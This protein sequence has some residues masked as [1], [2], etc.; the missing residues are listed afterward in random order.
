METSSPEPDP[1]KADAR[2]GHVTLDPAGDVVAGSLGAW[3]IVYTV[4]ACG[5]SPGG[6]IVLAR[7]WPADWGQPQWTAPTQRDYVTFSTTGAG[8]LV[9]RFELKKGGL[10]W[11]PDAIHALFV[12]VRD[13]TLGPGDRITV[14]LGDASAGSPG[15]LAQTF[16]EEAS[17]L[18][19]A[20][21]VY[22][23]GQWQRLPPLPAL[24][25][26]GGPAA[27]LVVLAPSMVDM[28][29]SFEVILRVED[30]WGNPAHGYGGCILL[31]TEGHES[32]SR[33][34]GGEDAGVARLPYRLTESGV[35]RLMARDEADTLSATSN[36]IVCTPSSS[37]FKLFWGD[38]H[39]QSQMGCGAR[40]V[41]DFLRHARDVAGVDFAAEQANDHYLSDAKWA[42]TQRV[43]RELHDP[44]RFVTFLGYEWS[45]ETA[46][47]GDHNVYYL[48]DEGPIRRS[49]HSLIPDPDSLE[50]DLGHITEVYDAFRGQRAFM[51]PHVGGRTADL[52]YHDR[53]L[54]PVIEIH[55]SHATSEWFLHEALQRDIRLGWWP[56]AMTS[57]AGPGPAAPATTWAV[58]CAA[59]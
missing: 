3:R 17:R 36:P 29:Q 27:R 9:P 25:V 8:R 22:G 51:T 23:D 1:G 55:S 2:L 54:E 31:E 52:T 50:S 47:G 15:M 35:H 21:D 41:E 43:V 58:T 6:G 10:A 33:Q 49:S 45:G 12:E 53:S 19:V 4:G 59:D 28:G 44:G 16:L 14:I 13:C 40:T 5:I 39:G 42:E 46:D 26:V 37:T 24:I 30:A 18:T 11:N 32:L 7:P 20:V 57:W 38:L 56:G 48:D 34:F